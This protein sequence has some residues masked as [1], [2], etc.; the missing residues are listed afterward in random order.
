MIVSTCAVCSSIASVSWGSRCGAVSV[1]EGGLEHREEGDRGPG[2][3]GSMAGSQ[4]AETYALQVP[5]LRQ[6]GRER[7]V[8]GG[9]SAALQ[10][11]SVSEWCKQIY[12]E[13]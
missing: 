11:Y 6:G 5:Q 7:W 9:R 12:C 2:A 3:Q 8:E 4:G 10:F 1:P 13:S